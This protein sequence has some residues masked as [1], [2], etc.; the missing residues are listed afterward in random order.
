MTAVSF[1]SSEDEDD[2]HVSDQ[3]D[4]KFGTGR[5][6]EITE[7]TFNYKVVGRLSH[8]E[9]GSTNPYT[10]SKMEKRTSS[11][12][13]VEKVEE[14]KITIKDFLWRLVHP[15]HDLTEVTIEDIERVKLMHDRFLADSQFSF[16]Y[17]TL[18]TVAAGI[19]GVGLVSNSS[20]SVIASML[21]SP[22]MGPVTAMSYSFMIGDFKLFR[23]ALMTEVF[24]ILYCCVVGVIIALCVLWT[25][26][27]EQLPTDEMT[28][29]SNWQ[30][31]ICSI[32]VAFFSG[33]G[34]AIGVLDSQTNS[35][36]GVAISASLLPPAVNFGVLFTIRSLIDEKENN[37]ITLLLTL[38]NVLVVLIASLF[39]FRLKEILP[40]EKSIFWSDLGIA[41]KI[42]HNVAIFP[43]IQ[44]EPDEK[45][46]KKRVTR[47]FPRCSQMAKMPPDSFR[48]TRHLNVPSVDSMD[49]AFDT[50][51][52][53]GGGGGVGGDPSPGLSRISEKSEGTL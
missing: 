40:I 52:P 44:E 19:A 11:F 4:L 47:F 48:E 32:P 26:M 6:K 36:V 43:I 5:R 50:F 30:N 31:F 37:F 20:A 12:V 45:E 7:D 9:G 21:V 1:E 42:Y 53:N 33:L 18:L 13:G 25:P 28:S 34:V 3:F 38:M 15:S 16:N 29:R 22:L 39:M 35:L 27:L 41:R 8:W 46:I 49:S 51:L 14:E 17:S 2:Q 24:S 10:Q 23:M